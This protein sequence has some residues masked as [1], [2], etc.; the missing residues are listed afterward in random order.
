MQK[1]NKIVDI[2][3]TTVKSGVLK[4]MFNQQYLIPIYP[5]QIYLSSK[6]SPRHIQVSRELNP[7]RRKKYARRKSIPPNP[8]ELDKN[9]HFSK[10][11]KKVKKR[12]QYL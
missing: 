8:W 12:K 9:I 4:S 3:I 1:C 2:E 11:W 7:F 6:R 10:S 5:N